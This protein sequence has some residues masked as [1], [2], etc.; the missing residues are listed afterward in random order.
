MDLAVLRLTSNLLC[1]LDRS[2]RLWASVSSAVNVLFGLYVTY[3]LSNT[4]ILE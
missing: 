4:A 1:D 3:V 2:L